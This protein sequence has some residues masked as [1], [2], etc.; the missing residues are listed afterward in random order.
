MPSLSPADELAM[1]RAQISGLRTR[2][3]DLRAALIDA[4]DAARHGHWSRVEVV[5]RT[6][7]VFDHRLLP[8]GLRDDPCYWRERPVI[9]VRCLPV[10]PRGLANWVSAARAR[11]AAADRPDGAAP[12]R[13]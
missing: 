10:Q 7:R 5:T 12:I 2:E 13:N 1:I 9:E 11:I 8:E 3:Q 4:P 6:V